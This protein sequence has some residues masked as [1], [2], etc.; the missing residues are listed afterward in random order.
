MFWY[1]VIA[2]LVLAWELMLVTLNYSI[3]RLATKIFQ[4]LVTLFI[5]V[6][7]D[8]TCKSFDY[9]FLA[10]VLIKET[11]VQSRIHSS[12]I[13]RSHVYINVNKIKG[14]EGRC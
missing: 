7:T 6:Y 2:K 1:L 5:F 3:C 10:A 4:I 13:S 12:E 8:D 11:F 14:Y 9:A